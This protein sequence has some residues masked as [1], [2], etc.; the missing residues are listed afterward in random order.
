MSNRNH[1]SAPAIIA[2][3][4]MGSALITRSFQ[5]PAYAPED[6]RQPG[7]RMRAKVGRY[8]PSDVLARMKN[9][10]AL[11]DS[12]YIKTT[13]APPPGEASEQLAAA[14]ARCA[15]LE[16]E[17][18]QA[19]GGQRFAVHTGMGRYDVIEGKKLNAEPMTKD[20]ANALCAG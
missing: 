12:G 19:S 5:L 2:A 7:N 17:K 8:I 16:K 13:A 9:R 10:R 6:I 15:E 18:A 20:E 14:L 11:E 1:R 3:A 4:A